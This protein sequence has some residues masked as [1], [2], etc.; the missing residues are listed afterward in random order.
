MEQLN[1]REPIAWEDWPRKPVFDF[2][3]A[4]SDPFYSV[5]FTVDVTRLHRFTSARGLSFYYALVYLCTQAVDRVDAFH[6]T[7]RDGALFRLHRRSPSFTDLKPGAEQFHIVT[8]PGT[9]DIAAF[10]QAARARS[11]AQT[12]FI[13]AEGESDALIYFSCLPWVELTAL[14][15][16]RD[17]DPDDAVP[18]IAWG[19]YVQTDGRLRLGLSME[20]NHRFVDGYHIGQFST[21]LQELMRA[22]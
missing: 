4:M 10:C 13:C 11:L 18:R 14:T 3:S 15:N 6:Y 19:R 21:A 20:L 17:F 5:T 1:D 9:G 8:M 7:V 12:A 2:F 16:E 22:L